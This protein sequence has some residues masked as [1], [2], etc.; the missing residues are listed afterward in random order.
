MKEE[1]K[2]YIKK[3]EYNPDINKTEIWIGNFSNDPTI[4]PID[5]I[6]EII[7]HFNYKN[8]KFIVDDYLSYNNG[9][10][11]NSPI[12][13]N[14]ITFNKEVAFKFYS[15][16]D[17]VSF[18]NCIFKE[19]IIFGNCTFA[20]DISFRNCSLR[21]NT[22]FWKTTFSST[23]VFSESK[24]EGFD[25]NFCQS[26]FYGDIFC[27]NI[28]VKSN[29][30]FSDSIFE[31]N[32]YFKGAILGGE[33]NFSEV[34]FKTNQKD[35]NVLEYINKKQKE[36]ID[37]SIVEFET[38][39]FKDAVFSKNVRFHKSIFK[40]T[41]NFTN[42]KFSK[43]VDFYCT[44]F[45]KPQQFH[46]T[47]FL[48]RAIFSNTEF[49]EEVQFLHC[50]VD[51]NSYIKFESVTFKKSLDISRSNFNDKA[52]FWNIELE[53][54]NILT[55]SKY[56]DDFE[57]HKN[58]INSEKTV[59]SI[60]KQ[61]RETYRIIKS[62]F[63]SQNNKIEG[64]KFYEKEMSVYLEEKREE[65]NKKSPPKNKKT[66]REK[67]IE[68]FIEEPILNIGLLLVSIFTFLWA[69]L[70][71]P[72][73]YIASVIFTSL[74]IL[75]IVIKNKESLKYRNPIKQNYYM[76]IILLVIATVLIY[77]YIYNIENPWYI[78]SAY[79]VL[80]CGMLLLYFSI[81]KDKIILW[82][83]K[84]SNEFDTN[85]VVGVNFSL[86][87][88]T[89]TYLIV[90][91]SM[92]IFTDLTIDNINSSIFLTSLVDVFN[93]TKWDNLE[94]IGVKLKGFSYLLL[95]IGRIFIGYGYYQ[96]IQA[97]RK[98]GKS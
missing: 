90:L 72:I 78:I 54:G 28:I 83:N 58:E 71:C 5:I 42:T 57:V 94:I 35:I 52:N 29:I 41:A 13:F 18:I 56:Q 8:Y 74:I 40:N 60:Y 86:L 51:S 45:Y 22:N 49:D 66:F 19:D 84:N 93:I 1:F 6:C 85:W 73:F 44:H 61:L 7:W 89:L 21:A 24:F 11:W 91:L 95:F 3:E 65:T 92:F 79:I 46:L 14:N 98:F 32:A 17:N 23:S 9:G 30:N 33:A 36:E 67:F 27:E 81:E 55:S 31:E 64:L 39:I 59:P 38:V 63:Y 48:D 97:F 96:T 70:K 53:E 26:H 62:N 50:R 68:K 47:D 76:P 77:I 82:F 37:F 25:N 12:I 15:F 10:F 4:D 88:G 69:I 87:V 2:K 34:K 20:K 16:E 80:L 43:L 75:G